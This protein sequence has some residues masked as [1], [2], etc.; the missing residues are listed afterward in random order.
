MHARPVQTR[1]IDLDLTAAGTQHG[2]LEVLRVQSMVQSA[3]QIALSTIA[4]PAG[5]GQCVLFLGL[6]GAQAARVLNRCLASL[7]ND[8][9]TGRVILVPSLPADPSELLIALEPLIDAADVVV[10]LDDA[11]DRLAHASTAIV[12]SSNDRDRQR[13][14]ESLMFA[15]GAAHSLRL[16]AP[17][18][19]DPFAEF[20]ESRERLLIS[21]IPG[22][23]G[24]GRGHAVHE[25][26]IGCRNL[27]VQTGVLKGELELRASRVLRLD[28]PNG[29]VFARHTGLLD[30]LRDPGQNVYR[31]SLLARVHPDG[32]SP[33]SA[34][35]ILAPRDGVLLAAASTERVAPGDC[36][37]V[38][39]EEMPL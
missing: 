3:V 23:T 8:S 26:T 30:L 18:G 39:A 22:N 27:L 34:I 14:A 33:A 12:R 5:T 17:A 10:T 35:G 2:Y 20:V 37:G 38:V 4:S 31:G 36:V 9:L 21:C 11:G 24:I 29:S 13:Q 32:S 6:R 15:F 7:C 1:L 19:G 28:P 25:A 16:F